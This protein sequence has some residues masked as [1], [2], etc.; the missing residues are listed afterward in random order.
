MHRN[1]PRENWQYVTENERGFDIRD[2]PFEKII[3]IARN[4]TIRYVQTHD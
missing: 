2:I 4:E 1:L 3:I